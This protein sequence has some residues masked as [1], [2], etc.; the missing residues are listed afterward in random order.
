MS[1]SGFHSHFKNVPAKKGVGK[2]ER[3]VKRH[4]LSNVIIKIVIIKNDRFLYFIE[5]IAKIK[6]GGLDENNHND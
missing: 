3:T 6:S 4:N 5:A 1:A 2:S